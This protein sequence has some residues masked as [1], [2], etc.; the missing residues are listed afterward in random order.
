M[1]IYLT[2]L[3][4]S[5]ALFALLYQALLAKETFFNQNRVFLLLSLLGGLALPWV[6]VQLAQQNSNT[7]LL[8]NMS[9]VLPLFT[10]GIAQVE[11]SIKVYFTGNQVWIGIWSVGIIVG[12]SRFLYGISTIIRLAQTATERQ[13]NTYYTTAIDMPFSFFKRI[14]IPEY[15]RNEP[16]LSII[17]RHEQAHAEG[18]HS[19]DVVLS[20]LVCIVFWWHPLV[21]W[22]KRQLRTLHEYIADEAAVQDCSRKQYGLLL[23]QQAQSGPVFAYANHFLQSPLKQ[24]LVMLAKQHSAPVRS[25]RYALLIPAVLFLLTVFQQNTL[26]AQSKNQEIVEQPDQVA[27]YPGGLPAL[28]K[29]LGENIKYPENARKEKAEG[30]A[31]IAFVINTT[32]GVESVESIKPIHQALA[33]EAIRVVKLTRWTPG[34]HEGKTVKVKFTLPVK[35]K[36]D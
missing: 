5:W 20:E 4:F 25:L 6:G 30:T 13:G 31:V 23:I 21:Y 22:Y 17:L 34:V 1:L 24:R 10:V 15:Y 32:G 14:F 11:Q 3:T 26:Y 33:D 18:N 2:Y 12:L 27:E 29:F 7:G 35:F 36:L 28:G 16:D 19:L 8:S 9:A